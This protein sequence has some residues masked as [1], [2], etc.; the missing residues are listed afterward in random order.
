MGK[1]T[2]ESPG[3][4]SVT[5]RASQEAGRCA[6][7]VRR[8]AGSERVEDKARV[9]GAGGLQRWQSKETDSLLELPGGTGPADTLI[10]VGLLT[11]RKIVRSCCFKPLSLW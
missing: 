4:Y 2:L 5:P 10:L 6:E 9:R 7:S 11:T 8:Q 3:G 1:I